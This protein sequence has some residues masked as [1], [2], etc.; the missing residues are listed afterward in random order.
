MTFRIVRPCLM[1][2]VLVALAINA[3]S[4]AGNGLRYTISVHEFRNEAGYRGKWDLG[5]GFATI[6]TDLLNNSDQFIVLGD[7]EMREA[8]LDEQDFGRSGRTAQGRRTP[9]TERMT[10]A[11]LLVRGSITHVQETGGGRGGINIGGFRIGGSGDRAE[12]NMTI[13]LV[14]TTTGQVMASQ[15]V[16]GNS[17]SRGIGLGYYGDRLGGLTGDMEGFTR[18]NL[19]KAC[20]DAVDEAIA[21][22][23][24]QLDNIQWE[25]TVMRVRDDGSVILNR[26]T[27]EGVREGMQFNV[28]EIEE[29][30]DPD[31]GELLDME[32][33]TVAEV[34][35][36][37]VRERITIA[38][39]VSGDNI[40]EG[41]SIFAK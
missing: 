34:E 20:A 17:G 7:R 4:A 25:G 10:P 16:T 23:I 13:Y 41:M 14:D 32:I 18:D 3:Q 28:G 38:R 33:K 29:L 31:T 12:V 26:G 15:S 24:E 1:L 21:F 9:E 35:A 5:R 8:A 36:T 6:M 40:E 37:E 27:R 39:I 11:Q 2:L 19:G 30:I 22:L